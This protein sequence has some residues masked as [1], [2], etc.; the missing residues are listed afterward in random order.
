MGVKGLLSLIALVFLTNSYCQEKSPE[1]VITTGHNDMVHSMV[2]SDNGK[3]FASSSNNKIIKI[4]I[5]ATTMEYRTLSGMDGR[6]HQMDFA[7]DNIHLAGLSSHDQLHIWNVMTGES[8][9][10]IEA[11]G[12][13]KG[14]SFIQNDTKI[15]HTSDGGML[16]VSDVN[17][18]ETVE[19]EVY[20][21]SF[22]VDKENEIAYVLNHLGEMVCFDLK[23][24]SIIKTIRLFKEFNFPFTRGDITS[25]GRFIAYGFND[26]V[27]RIWDTQL[28]KFVYESKKYDSKLL[29]LKFDELKSYLYVAFHDGKVQVFDFDKYKVKKEFNEPHFITQSVT[30]HPNG[31]IIVMANNQT[32]RFYNVKTKKIFKEL[33]GKMQEVVN[34]TYDQQGHYLAV[35][36]DAATI[37]VWDLKLNKIVRTIQGFFPCQFTAD[38][39]H[40]ITMQYTMKLGMWDI[41]TGELA[42][43][44]DAEYELIQC[45]AISPD[46]KYLAGAG[47]MNTIKVWNLES[48]EMIAKIPGHTGGITSLDFHPTKPWLAS[49][50]YDQTS[51]VWNFETKEELVKFDDQVTNVSG[52]KFSPDGT[53]LTTS[54]WDKT[55]KIRNVS[56]WSTKYTLEGHISVITSIDYNKDG[57]VLVSGGGNSAVGAADNSLIFWDTKTGKMLCQL[58]DHQG[59]ITKVVFDKDANRVFSS[60]DDGMIKISDHNTCEVIASYLSLGDKEFMIFTPDNYYMASRNALK[61]IAFR[62]NNELVPFEQFDIYLNRPDIV[63]ERIGKSPEQLIKAYNYLYKKR[64][65]KLEMDEGSLK[66]DYHMPNLINESSYDLVTSENSINLTLKVWDDI[67][68]IQ[69]INIFVNDVPIYGEQGFR[70]SETV[71]S[72]RGDFEIPLIEG[73]NKVQLSCMNSNGAESMFETIEIIREGDGSKHDLYIVAMGVS[74]YQDTRFNLTYPT[75]DA[76]D[77]V[78]DLSIF[79]NGIG[80]NDGVI[81]VS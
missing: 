47:F 71:K 33:G 36:T 24:M 27:L 66:L 3:L 59:G 78:E 18:G 76:T 45:L 5:V 77:M 51:R 54:A 44:L 20:S 37:Q 62:I 79:A 81:Y 28:E 41:E 38:G 11:S 64:L 67:Y 13:S 10:I 40:L 56:D 57:S 16:A 68:T 72:Y 29:D 74:D 65:R 39:K 15:V 53:C 26:D 4:W 9:L 75:K 70:P 80:I 55:I 48:K 42:H 7:D 35:A 19:T 43:S 21:T 73:V 12:T 52:V 30:S 50:S 31:N 63:A 23:T 25:D 2:M 49:G 32:I 14:L 46:G 22:T 8:K 17:S 34:M 58:K 6:V 60:A 69:Q 1:V 61:G